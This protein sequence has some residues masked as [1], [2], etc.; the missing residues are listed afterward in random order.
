MN[1]LFWKQVLVITFLFTSHWYALTF[2]SI[3]ISWRSGCET[4]PQ[5]S[6]GSHCMWTRS[7]L[8]CRKS[9]CTPSPL[10]NFERLRYWWRQL[11]AAPSREA[12]CTFAEESL[13]CFL[14]NACQCNSIKSERLS[15]SGVG[16]SFA[17]ARLM[18]I[19]DETKW[20][21]VDYFLVYSLLPEKGDALMLGCLEIRF[22]RK[23][24]IL[25]KEAQF[26]SFLFS[27][28]V[29][30]QAI[31]KSDRNVRVRDDLASLEHF[32][33]PNFWRLILQL[34][35]LCIFRIILSSLFPDGTPWFFSNGSREFVF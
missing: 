2:L 29:D 23:C 20:R 33:K 24:V 6:F 1:N 21:D 15:A 32:C 19:E 17:F 10:W 12:Q 30:A 35:S 31:Y 16:F 14:V 18:W 7:R 22:L 34:P 27:A 25:V 13:A 5:P 26:S 28:K 4:T 3:L 8:N 11:S 9:S